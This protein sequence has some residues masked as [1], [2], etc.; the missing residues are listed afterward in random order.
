MSIG[1]NTVTD[2]SAKIKFRIVFAGL[3]LGYR[4]LTAQLEDVS[5]IDVDVDMVGPYFSLG[6]VF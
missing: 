3:E 1:D 5:G 6:A 4:Q 2:I